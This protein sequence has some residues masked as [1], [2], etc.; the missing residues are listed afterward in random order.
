VDNARE[1]LVLEVIR[2]TSTLLA[3]IA[4]VMGLR[5]CN[6]WCGGKR[7]RRRVQRGGA[8]RRGPGPRRSPRPR[9]KR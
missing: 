3:I 5:W 9:R 8:R 1:L 4:A 2:F 7:K 6:G